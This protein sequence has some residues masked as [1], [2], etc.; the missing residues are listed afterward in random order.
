MTCAALLVAFSSF[1]AP[2]CILLKGSP[3]LATRMDQPLGLS[4]APE[5]SQCCFDTIPC[6][7]DHIVVSL[8]RLSE[9]FEG[10]DCV[11]LSSQPSILNVTGAQEGCSFWIGRHGGWRESRVICVS[12]FLHSWASWLRTHVAS[13]V[14]ITSHRSL[15][16][17]N[18]YFHHI[19]ESLWRNA[20][21]SSTFF[22][23][24]HS[25]CHLGTFEPEEPGCCF[26]TQCSKYLYKCLIK[27]PSL[28]VYLVKILVSNFIQEI[29]RQCGTRSLVYIL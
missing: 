28:E 23:V 10:R 11:I 7:C 20:L 13:F 15:T 14:E 29:S 8:S 18:R 24:A 1:L 5:H 3:L 21:S 9:L 27:C 22:C 2:N 26:P 25:P 16:A 4:V 6:S 17:K 12:L 19:A